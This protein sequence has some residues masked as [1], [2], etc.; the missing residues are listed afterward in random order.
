MMEYVVSILTIGFFFV[1]FP[2]LLGLVLQSNHKQEPDYIYANGTVVEL[3]LFLI[4]FSVAGYFDLSLHRLSGVYFYC[5]LAVAAIALILVLKNRQKC[6]IKRTTMMS[7]A[8]L[9]I[10]VVV[11]VILRK[12]TSS[13]NVMELALYYSQQDAYSEYFIAYYQVLA[14][15]CGI[16]VTMLCKWI[17]PF[18]VIFV[19]TALYREI[20]G[21]KIGICLLAFICL[22][23][24]MLPGYRL[25][26]E[27]PWTA[28]AW[29][30]YV[31]FPMFFVLV[32]AEQFD[33]AQKVSWIAVLM[34]GIVCALQ[35][36]G[37]ILILC[38]IA[39]ALAIFIKKWLAKC[40]IEKII[41]KKRVIIGAT[42]LFV[43][44]SVCTGGCIITESEYA[45]PDNRFKM[46]KQVMEI[47]MMVEPLE[48][49]KM[50]APPEVM[51]QINDGD[52]KV[53][54]FFLREPEKEDE[55]VQR[56]QEQMKKDLKDN[57]YVPE[58]LIQHALKNGCNLVVAKASW[59][60]QEELFYEYGFK[61]IGE[62]AD[63]KVY[64]Y[65]GESLWE[66]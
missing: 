55:S 3:T 36:Y 45:I 6:L 31:I 48:E 23:F 65:L 30:Y 58:K 22:C 8:L 63:Y 37:D 60:L 9:M 40:S 17:I 51:A 4:V 39:S 49:V 56:Q 54:P 33:P 64:Q 66:Q 38:L 28:E 41:S 14:E 43:I 62:T 19:L 61:M 1:L 59:E 25:L 16:H 57:N 10:G 21:K 18:I 34:L 26:W 13:D 20:F 35:G 24:E 15:I 47:R 42:V 53:T 2:M 11:F 29:I 32:S 50:I 52:L 5:A 12:D 7:Y 44:V 27:A 46:D